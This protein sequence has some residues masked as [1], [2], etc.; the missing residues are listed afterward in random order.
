M[1]WPLGRTRSPRSPASHRL[2][3]ILS[4]LGVVGVALGAALA[5][6]PPEWVW[7]GGLVAIAACALLIIVGALHAPDGLVGRALALPPVRWLGIISYSLY[8]WHWP[9]YAMAAGGAAG[10][11]LEQEALHVGP[12]RVSQPI[13][14]ATISAIQR[15]AASPDTA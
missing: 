5:G 2:W 13:T 11:L 9:V 6:G 12:L 7:D 1:I 8:L 4:V 3:A 10:V 15:L 14:R